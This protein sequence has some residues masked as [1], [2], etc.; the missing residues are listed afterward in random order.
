MCNIKE[1]VIVITGASG[2][3]GAAIADAFRIAGAKRVMID[4]IASRLP[5]EADDVLPLAA[6]LTGAKGAEE[7]TRRASEKFGRID[8]LVNVVGG[9]RGGITTAES[10]WSV[11]EAMLSVN[12][13]SA[14]AMT[15]A[16]LPHFSERG[17]SI[18]NIGSM[19]ALNGPAGEAAYAGAK[20]ALLRFTESVAMELKDQGVRANTILPGA[21]DTPA[22]RSWMNDAQKA[23]AIDP[24]AIAE[25]ALFL[26][27]DASRAVTGAAI[28]ATGRQ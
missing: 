26:A 28:R 22:N 14:V 4:Q 27:S 11:W 17:G 7:A 12:L 20:A 24:A 9:Y 8:A 10:D 3:L 13:Q 18:V 19:A 5:Q 6:D 16:V 2:S 1:R 23:T 25:V 21:M 15:R